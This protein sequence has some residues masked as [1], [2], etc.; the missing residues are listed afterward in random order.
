M[1]RPTVSRPVYLGFKHKFGAY[2][3]IFITVDNCVTLFLTSER[4]CRLLLR[5]AVARAVILG[6]ES[7]GTRDHISLSQIRDSH[8]LEIQVPVFIS[9]RSRVAQLYPQALGSFP[10]PPSTRRATV[11]VFEPASTRG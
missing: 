6:S 5:L 2:D 1:L 8:N 4:V 9:P 3:K 11:E 10:S 7:R